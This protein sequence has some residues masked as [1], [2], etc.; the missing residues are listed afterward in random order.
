M[1]KVALAALLTSGLMAADHGM[2]VGLDLGNTTYDLK[3][4]VGGI[5]VTDS[6][7]DG[8]QTLTVGYYLDKN[9]RLSAFFQNINTSGG[10]SRSYGIGYDYLIGD[11]ALKPFVGPILGNASS[12][13]DDA[14]IN[15]SGAVYGAQIGLDYAINNNFSIEAGY[16]Y[17]KTNMNDTVKVL[18]TDIKVEVEETRNWFI[19]ALYKF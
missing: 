13:A 16:R 11:S 19:G 14:R 3:A 9:I 10:T 4:S 2:Y 6:A 18:G 17:M 15:L 1:K 5:S 7:D 8:A 12:K